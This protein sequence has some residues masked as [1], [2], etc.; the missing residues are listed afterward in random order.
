MEVEDGEDGASAGRVGGGTDAAPARPASAGAIQQMM[1]AF[2]RGHQAR[3][4]VPG[5]GSTDDAAGSGSEGQQGSG[6]HLAGQVAVA[7]D[8]A[9]V[10]IGKERKRAKKGTG[11]SA[12]VQD[13][14]RRVREWGIQKPPRANHSAWNYAFKYKN[15][16][17]NNPAGYEHQALC[18]LCLQAKNLERAT[19]KLGKSDSP[20]AL[21][22]HLHAVHPEAH[23]ECWELEE[24]RNP[25]KNPVAVQ[26]RRSPRKHS[27]NS[28]A[29]SHVDTVR[30]SLS[31][32]FEH[33]A[34]SS[35]QSQASS[36][37]HAASG[38][39]P[40]RTQGLHAHMHTVQAASAANKEPD[41]RWQDFLAT[42]HSV[43]GQVVT[44]KR[45]SL[46][47]S[48]VTLLVFLHEAIP[49]GIEREAYEIIEGAMS[50]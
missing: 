1:V 37:E 6:T 43:S 28:H 13:I 16:P 5:G 25:A 3:G 19:I 38:A 45:A 17:K 44:A 34:P 4:G 10:N 32:L 21:M 14:A 8:G 39:A 41:P 31:K 9:L 30:A 40:A 18:S 26:L 47:P 22:Q 33:V 20:T 49:G 23:Q 7:G 2:E 50:R 46:H 36:Q 12:S 48:T 42:F 24:Q 29:T 15:P 11:S 27:S 35:S